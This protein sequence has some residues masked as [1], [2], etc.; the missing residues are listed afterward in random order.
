MAWVSGFV[1]GRRGGYTEAVH[2][3]KDGR[4]NPAN[5]PHPQDAGA[6]AGPVRTVLFFVLYAALI[7]GAVLYMRWKLARDDGGGTDGGDAPSL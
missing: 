2:G 6:E 3:T 5:L 4:M 1:D 7:V